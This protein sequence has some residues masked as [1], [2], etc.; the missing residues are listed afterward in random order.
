MKITLENNPNNK[1]RI[2]SEVLKDLPEWFGMDDTI[3]EY[4]E[5]SA[6]YPLWVAKK[7]SGMVKK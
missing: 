4:V 3:A 1:Q 2:V 7:R 5:N 6:T